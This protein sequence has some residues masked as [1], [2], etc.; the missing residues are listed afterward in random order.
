VQHFT[1]SDGLQLA[2][3][4]DDFTD[5]S[6]HPICENLKAAAFEGC[7]GSRMKCNPGR[8]TCSPSRRHDIALPSIRGYDATG[9]RA[10]A[11]LRGSPIRPRLIQSRNRTGGNN[12]SRPATARRPSCFTSLHSCVGTRARL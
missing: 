8:N 9:P 5:A 7:N 11:P 2:Y 4:I 12:S 1:A 10:Y 6:A 3:A